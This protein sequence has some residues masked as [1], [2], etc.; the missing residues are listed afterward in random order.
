MRI[1]FGD[2]IE[3]EVRDTG[4]GIARDDLKTIFQDYKQVN[5]VEARKRKGTGLGLALSQKLCM[6]MGGRHFRRQRARPRRTVYNSRS[7]ILEYRRRSN[8]APLK[9]PR[10]QSARWREMPKEETL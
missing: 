2:W 1:E 5:S 8:R 9:T 3:I 6:M 7:G 4:I 10:R